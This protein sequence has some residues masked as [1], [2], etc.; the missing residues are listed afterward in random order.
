M[1]KSYNGTTGYVLVSIVGLKIHLLNHLV[2]E[3]NSKPVTLSVKSVIFKKFKDAHFH[4]FCGTNR[5]RRVL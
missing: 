4:L 5:V 1:H 2:P 3:V